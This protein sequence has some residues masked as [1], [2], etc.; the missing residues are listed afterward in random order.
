MDVLEDIVAVTREAEASVLDEFHVIV[1]ALRITLMVGL[2][3]GFDKVTL[4]LQAVDEVH[5]FGP[6]VRGA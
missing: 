2:G 6:R 3:R 4:A 5:P 1:N